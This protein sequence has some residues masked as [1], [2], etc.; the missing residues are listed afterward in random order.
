MTVLG[1][2]AGR[3]YRTAE[4]GTEKITGHRQIPGL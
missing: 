1:E 4:L 3:G 2:L